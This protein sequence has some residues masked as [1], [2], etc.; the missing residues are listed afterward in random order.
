MVI[1]I[2]AVLEAIAAPR[3]GRAA[4]GAREA[5]F[6]RDLQ[7]FAKAI[8][9]YHA[10]TGL[11]PPDFDSGTVSGPFAAYVDVRRF[12]AQTPL[13]GKWDIEYESYGITSAVGVHRSHVFTP[14][15]LLSIDRAIDDGSLHSGRLRFIDG[16]KRYYLVIAE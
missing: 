3:M 12:Q 13:G 14:D 2:L 6:I 15:E 10:E 7:I 4:H 16:P 5:A 1:V 9:L 11:Y 8:D